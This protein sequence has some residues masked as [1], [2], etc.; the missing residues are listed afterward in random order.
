MVCEGGRLGRLLLLLSPEP[1]HMSQTVRRQCPQGHPTHSQ[2]FGFLKACLEHS[3]CGLTSM[4]S[5]TNSPYTNPP[6]TPTETAVP[7]RTR[8]PDLGNPYPWWLWPHTSPACLPSWLHHPFRRSLLTSKYSS[9][10][11]CSVVLWIPGLSYSSLLVGFFSAESESREPFTFLSH[12]LKSRHW[13]PYPI[14]PP[15]IT[16]T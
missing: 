8:V 10:Q 6:G 1:G 11:A 7:S 2:T 14:S 9:S 4:D 5:S 16:I 3:F 15:Y 12:I 13:Y